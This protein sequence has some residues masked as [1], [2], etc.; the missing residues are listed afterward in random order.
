MSWW[1]T[2]GA[3]VGVVAV[4]AVASWDLTYDTLGGLECLW[5]ADLGFRGLL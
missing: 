2:T 5:L 1:S 4:A 3:V